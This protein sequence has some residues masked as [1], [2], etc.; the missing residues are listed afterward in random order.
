MLPGEIES[1]ENTKSQL[2]SAGK[3]HLTTYD[4]FSASGRTFILGH[5][6]FLFSSQPFSFGDSSR[7]NEAGSAAPSL[8][9]ARR[10]GEAEA[11]GSS[12]DSGVKR[13]SL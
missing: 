10:D 4:H 6:V 5:V 2:L 3:F 1:A 8:R 11:A 9:G 12:R 13:S 7:T